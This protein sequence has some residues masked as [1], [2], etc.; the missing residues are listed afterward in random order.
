MSTSSQSEAVGFVQNSVLS[1]LQFLYIIIFQ[2][3]ESF[4]PPSSTP[5]GGIDRRM[6][7]RTFLY[8]IQFR[9]TFIKNFFY[10]MR[11]FDSVEP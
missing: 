8:K 5:G 1:N 7:S 10:I 3:W 6:H 9:T 11:I 2:R 4:E